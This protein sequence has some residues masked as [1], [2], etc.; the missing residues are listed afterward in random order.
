MFEGKWA[1]DRDEEKRRTESS[2]REEDIPP[3]PGTVEPIPENSI[4]EMDKFLNKVKAQKK[5][6]MK[7]R[8][9]SYKRPIVY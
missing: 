5:E 1:E 6:E 7:E 3:P 2:R 9:K 8:N 4:E